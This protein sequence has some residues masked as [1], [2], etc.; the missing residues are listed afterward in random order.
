M[1]KTP[2]VDLVFDIDDQIP[3]ILTGDS[4]RITQIL[5]NLLS[6]SIKFTEKGFIK[7]KLALKESLKD[8]I[9]IDFTVEDSGIVYGKKIKKIFSE[10]RQSTSSINRKYGGTG[11]G[12]PIVVKLLRLMGS[13]IHMDSTYGKGTTFSFTLELN[14]SRRETLDRK[15]AF[16]GYDDSLNNKSILLV[17]DNKVNQLVVKLLFNEMKANVDV[18]ENGEECIKNHGKESI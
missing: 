13:E 9:R 15:A 17:E 18:V 4:T 3:N 8:S 14:V 6:N 5:Y 2:G 11:L 16:A 10:F 12:L 1:L 7:L